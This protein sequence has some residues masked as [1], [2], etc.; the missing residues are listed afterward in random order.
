MRLGIIVFIVKKLG[1]SESKETLENKVPSGRKFVSWNAFIC[2]ACAK[3]ISDMEFYN[4]KHFAKVVFV[5]IMGIIMAVIQ[6]LTSMFTM[7]IKTEIEHVK[8][9]GVALATVINFVFTMMFSNS[10]GF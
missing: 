4:D 7:K 10:N 3:I 8:A 2:L 9:N 6:K 1:L 5:T